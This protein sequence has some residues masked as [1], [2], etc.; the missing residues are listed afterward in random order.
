MK[1]IDAL[2]RRMSKEEMAE[3]HR[4]YLEAIEPF[5]KA[6]ADVFAREHPQMFIQDGALSVVYSEAHGALL[7]RYREVC[8]EA[9]RSCFGFYPPTSAAPPSPS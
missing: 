9:F 2:E 8:R 5:G 4:A 6:L 1:A 7:E 3:R